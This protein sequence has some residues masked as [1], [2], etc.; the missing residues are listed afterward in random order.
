MEGG[1]L[2]VLPYKVRG[3]RLLYDAAAV[4]GYAVMRSVV[5]VDVY[6]DVATVG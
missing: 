5:S 3:V 2:P 6:F 1:S 4:G